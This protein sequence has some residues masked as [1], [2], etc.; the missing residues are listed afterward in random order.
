MDADT[1]ILASTEWLAM[2]LYQATGIP[3]IALPRGPTQLPVDVLPL[4]E[5]FKRIYLWLED[6]EQGA[7]VGAVADKF[8]RHPQVASTKK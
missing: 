5:R 4:L 2:A 7:D 3:A 8:A 1:V 6:A